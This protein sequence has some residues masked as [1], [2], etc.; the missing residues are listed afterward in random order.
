MGIKRD[1]QKNYLE[2]E[3]RKVIMVEKEDIKRKIMKNQIIQI[4]IKIPK[5]TMKINRILLHLI[6][7]KD[8]M[9]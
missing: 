3:I 2:I 4:T 9:F 1:I 7:I 5:M 8:L 6:E